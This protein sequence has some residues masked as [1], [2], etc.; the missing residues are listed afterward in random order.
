MVMELG[1]IQSQQIYMFLP[2]TKDIWETV[3]Q[4]YLKKRDVAMLFEFSL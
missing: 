2:I 3:R 1:A 4:T